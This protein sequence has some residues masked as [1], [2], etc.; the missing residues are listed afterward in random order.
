MK[1][2]ECFRMAM[3][4]LIVDDNSSMREMMKIHLSDLTE[5]FC[6]CDDGVKALSLY[7]NFHPDWVLMDWEMKQMDGLT[8]TR[9]IVENFP[10]AQILLVTQYDDA[11]LREAATEAGAYGFV[12]K[13]D[14]SLLRTFLEMHQ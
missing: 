13:E 7:E 6:E 9:Q 11:E 10:E 8:A 5:D 2:P 3:K 14:L 12:L 1:K 4:I